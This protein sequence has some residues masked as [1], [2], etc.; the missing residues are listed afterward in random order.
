MWACRSNPNQA[1]TPGPRPGF[2]TNNLQCVFPDMFMGG[3]HVPALPVGQCSEW[4][5]RLIRRAAAVKINTAVQSPV[6]TRLSYR[7]LC[8]SLTRMCI[9]SNSA[10]TQKPNSTC[11]K[12][13]QLSTFELR[14]KW[15]E[16]SENLCLT[17]N[18]KWNCSEVSFRCFPHSK[19]IPAKSRF[20]FSAFPRLLSNI[21]SGWR[22]EPLLK[23]T[24]STKIF[25]FCCEESKFGF[26]WIFILT[27]NKA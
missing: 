16:L 23:R 15:W 7:R 10:D 17:W 3:Q 26:V 25:R 12:F 4:S 6:R 1:V 21:S 18:L 27:T 11:P 8:W 20:Y 5:G 14:D 13:S 24:R 22:S 19:K 9:I 2:P